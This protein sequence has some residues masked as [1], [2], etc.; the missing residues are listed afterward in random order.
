[1][2]LDI[3]YRDLVDN[4]PTG[5]FI[6]QD[7]LFQF[8]N[9]SICRILGYSLEE[10]VNN[11]N[12]FDVIHKDDNI[13]VKENI[14]NA[15]NSL[16]DD[17]E[18][19]CR[20]VRKDGKIIKVKLLSHPIKHDERS[21]VLINVIEL[22]NHEKTEI[23]QR[24]EINYQCLIENS[25]VGVYVIQ[26]NLFK[27]V[28]KRF[29]EIFGYTYEEIVGKKGPVDLAC[30]DSKMLVVKNIK[31]RLSGEQD[32]IEYEFKVVRKDGKMI[33]V[34]VL[35]TVSLYREREALSGTLIDITQNKNIE[36]ELRISEERLRITL[37]ATNIGIWDWDLVNDVWYASPI[38]YSMLGYK[39]NPEEGDRNTWLIRIHPEDRSM[40]EKKIKQVLK[41]KTSSYIYEARI[42][43]ANGVYRWMQA[44][45]YIVGKNDQGVPTRLVGIRK[46]INDYKIALE[47]LKKNERQLRTLLDTIPDLVWLKDPKG[48][49]LQ[50]NHRFEMLYGEEENTIIGK[51][52]YDFIDKELADFFR[53]KDEEAILLGGPSVNEEQVTFASDGHQEVLETIKTPIFEEDGSVMGVLGIG[54]DITRRKRTETEL[55]ENEELFRTL[56]RLVP[57]QVTLTD[58][59]LH[60]ILVNDAFLYYYNT[61]ENE[62]IGKTATEIGFTTDKITQEYII[63]ELKTKGKVERLEL[64]FKDK[65]GNQREFIYSCII[66]RWKNKPMILHSGVDITEN[67]KTELELENY[68]KHLELLVKKRTDELDASNAELKSINKMLF[69]QKEELQAALDKLNETKN[70][71]IQSEKMASLGVLSAGIAHEINNPLNFIHGG[72]LCLENFLKEHLSDNLDEAVSFLDAIKVGVKRASAI[73][74]SLSHYSRQSDKPKMDCNMHQIIDNCLVMLQNQLKGRIEVKR[75]YTSKAHTIFGNEG[76]LHQALL[77]VLTNAEQAIAGKGV[78]SI[79]TEMVKNQFVISVSDSGAGIEHEVIEKIFD[80][81]FTTKLPGN[82][83]GLGLSITYNIIHEHGGTI[84]LISEKS[85]GTKAIIKL[86]LSK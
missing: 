22:L 10:I 62:V 35:G 49:Y 86:P 60:L 17:V 12:L 59:D 64:S 54:R 51:T 67:K 65:N 77:N 55:K 4:S 3:N 83:T 73:V 45:G 70:Q 15:L 8:A 28:N 71:L 27:Y 81:F 25:H 68:R 24:P 66:I 18:C 58:L 6:I 39:P 36:N 38:Y 63:H 82:G 76:K 57:N 61:N 21:A 20:M 33:W 40:V 30:D 32:S 85:K 34:R 48:V 37:D 74:T 41:H 11:K 42:M 50:C 31:K 52:D 47:N 2:N 46:D 16:S 84:R 56:L 43:D 79:F 29:C 5:I 9:K 80:P 26:D 72:S 13:L 78:I 19:Y 69:T 7:N 23:L 75:K 53:Q 44:I 14:L 1:M